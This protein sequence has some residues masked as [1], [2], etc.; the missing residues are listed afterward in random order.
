VNPV[1][2]NKTKLVKVLK[3]R[4]SEV[5]KGINNV[6]TLSSDLYEILDGK[7]PRKYGEPP[8]NL[9]NFEMIAPS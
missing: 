8:E 9:G 4:I 7:E 6:N 5:Q 2:F 1:Y 3:R